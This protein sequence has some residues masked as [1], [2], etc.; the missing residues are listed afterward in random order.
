V[1]YVGL[2]DEGGGGGESDEDGEGA[3]MVKQR[4]WWRGKGGEGDKVKV[5]TRVGGEDSEVKVG[6][7]KVVKV[8]VERMWVRRI[9]I[10]MVELVRLMVVAMFW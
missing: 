6:N 3:K 9:K 4:S 5:R 10:V 7:A 8:K 1:V 2:D